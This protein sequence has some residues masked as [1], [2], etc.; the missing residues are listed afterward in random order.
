M[1]LQYVRPFVCKGWAAS[2][3]VALCTLRPHYERIRGSREPQAVVL[4][5]CRRKRW[6]NY[7]LLRLVISEDFEHSR[8]LGIVIGMAENSRFCLN[9]KCRAWSSTTLLSG[10][11]KTVSSSSQ[12]DKRMWVKPVDSDI[13]SRAYSYVR[14][15][16]AYNHPDVR[17]PPILLLP[18]LRELINSTYLDIDIILSISSHSPQSCS[19][20]ARGV[21]RTLPLNDILVHQHSQVR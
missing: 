6:P 10:W 12:D 21:L 14:P 16:H 5:S 9:N 4:P 2:Y 17:D 15:R 11:E 3:S 8:I 18:V 1:G 19:F 7:A 20:D 13:D